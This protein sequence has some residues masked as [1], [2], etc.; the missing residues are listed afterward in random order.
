MGCCDRVLLALA[1]S[2]CCACAVEAAE[3]S[4]G[5]QGTGALRNASPKARQLPLA[6]H[7]VRMP[8]LVG[9]APAAD[10]GPVIRGYDTITRTRDGEERRQPAGQSM[11][12]ALDDR[13]SMLGKTA[14]NRLIF[15]EDDRVWVADTTAYPFR[16]IGM[17]H[18]RMG[19]GR[20]G[21]CS[22]TL[23]GPRT[24]LTAAHCLYSHEEGGWFEDLMFA[25][26]LNGATDAPYGVYGYEAVHVFDGFISN[27]SGSYGS[28]VQWDI[29]MVV[30]DQPVGNEL[31]WMP[32]A[33]D[34][35]LAGFRASLV[36]YPAD[37]PAGTMWRADCEVLADA[38][39]DTYFRYRCD[40]FPGS[41]GSPVYVE[42]EAEDVTIR[43]VNVAEGPAGNTAVRINRVYLE[44]LRALVR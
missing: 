16:A 37:K 7:P 29:G 43:G 38:I 35:Q 17:L 24:L 13:R 9:D 2:L 34:E 32:F 4:T 30:L 23:I 42:G 31:G 36:G 1:L 40:T 15:G 27:Y 28:V 39:Q 3:R 6:G 41:S 10:A 33:H 12:R 14:G 21:N 22:A 8:R 11:K 18:G 25:P 5:H 19:S 44:W 26:G 20:P